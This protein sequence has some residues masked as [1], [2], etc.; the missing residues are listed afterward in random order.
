MKASLLRRMILAQGLVVIVLWLLTVGFILLVAF[1]GAGAGAVDLPSK[2]Q[3]TT[4]L[5]LLQDEQDPA[6]FQLQAQRMQELAET[7]PQYSEA[8]EEGYRAIFQI[9][10]GQGRLRFRSEAAPREL[11]T[12]ARSG[13]H[14][15]EREGILYRV[16]VLEAPAGHLRVLV[17]DS[18]TLRRRAILRAVLQQSPLQFSILFLGL[19]FCTWLVSRQAL[20]PLRRLAEGVAARHPGDLSPLVGHAELLETQPL[21]KAL[22]RLFQQVR[23][24]LETQRR[25]TADAAHELRTP[26]AVIGAQAHVLLHAQDPTEREGAGRELQLGVERGA[27]A[28]RQLLSVARLEAT[29]Q[30]LVPTSMDLAT[31]ARERVESLVPQALKKDQDLGF[32][33]PEALPW[34]GD[35]AVLG[36]ALDNLLMNALLYTPPGGR[37]TLRLMPGEGD[38]RIEVEDTG[39]GILPEFLPCAFERFTRLPGNPQPGSGL[40]LAIVQRAVELHGGTVALANRID[41]TGLLATIHLPRPKH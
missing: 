35:G 26:L 32:E 36:S 10:D 1:G 20:K 28:I 8:K 16:R 39:P 21:V 27:Q 24:L 2:I 34:Q 18:I 22:N 12:Q 13:I 6:R 37:I 14:N 41:G 33:G 17:A 40:G 23:S 38:V 3:A 5:A 7:F 25:F 9:A 30:A 29:E 4:M 15:L 11:L 31:L 19:A